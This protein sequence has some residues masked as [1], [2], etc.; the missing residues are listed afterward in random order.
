MGLCGG[1]VRKGSNV[2]KGSDVRESEGDSE[3][4]LC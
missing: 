3:E 4:S 1:G 2:G